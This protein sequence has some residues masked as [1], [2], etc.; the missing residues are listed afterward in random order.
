MPHCLVFMCPNMHNTAQHNLYLLDPPP[1]ALRYT[2]MNTRAK[3]QKTGRNLPTFAGVPVYACAFLNAVF[4]LPC[5]CDQQN[6][7]QTKHSYRLYSCMCV[8]VMRHR[9]LPDRSRNA[10]PHAYSRSH[11]NC[12]MRRNVP[13]ADLAP[14]IGIVLRTNK[15]NPNFIGTSKKNVFEDVFSFDK[16]ILDT[17]FSRMRPL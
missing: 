4:C 12:A 17:H 16:I 5:A 13:G 2:D 9:C 6:H 1:A 14:V 10:A 11:L 3:Q 8:C 7:V 15:H